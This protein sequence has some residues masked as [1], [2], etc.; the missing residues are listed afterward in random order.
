[1]SALYQVGK[2][3]AGK[4][5]DWLVGVPA[6]YAGNLTNV[7][8]SNL[9]KLAP[10]DSTWMRRA[11]SEVKVGE[12]FSLGTGPGFGVA[13]L[14]GGFNYLQDRASG[15]TV[16]HAAVRNGA[17]VV[18]GTIAQ[19]PFDAT[20][21]GI[22]AGLLVGGAASNLT[23]KTVDVAWEPVA[24]SVETVRKLGGSASVVLSHRGL[25]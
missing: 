18:V 19:A 24:Q 7:W 6:G 4:P 12:K 17:A 5:S 3:A 25:G 1:M 13:S 11:L 10:E 8:S 20:G 14:F 9:A 16:A 2:A 23:A 15:M 21:V 22:P